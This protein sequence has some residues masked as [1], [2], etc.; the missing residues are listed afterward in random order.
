MRNPFQLPNLKALPAVVLAVLGFAMASASAQSDELLSVD[1]EPQEA[2]SALV[3]LAKTSGKQILFAKGV[4]TQVEVEG[5]KGEYRFEDALAALL[6]DTDLEYEF[7][8]ENLILVQPAKQ[9]ADSEEDEEDEESDPLELSD[10]VV[11]GSRI[12]REDWQKPGQVIVLSRED[13]ES[14][15]A[16]TLEQALRNLPQ[17]TNGVT[18]FGGSRNWGSGSDLHGRMLGTSNINGSSTINLRGLGDSATL[19][20]VDGKRVGD[21]GLLGGFSDISAIPISIIER[22]EIQLDGASS[23]YGSDAIGGVVN[24]ILRKDYD[25]MTMSFRRTSRTGGG[26]TEDNASVLGGM[27]WGSGG[28]RANVDGY[29]SSRQRQSDTN[30]SVFGTEPYGY[31]GN[32]RGRRG[33]QYGPREISPAFTQLAR[34]A[35]LIG[36]DEVVKKVA[37]PDGQDG[38]GLKLED[39]LPNIGV[40]QTTAGQD[41]PEISLT[42]KSDRL[43]FKV[44]ARQEITPSLE[45][46]G[47][48]TYGTRETFS[49]TGNPVGTRTFEV[50]AENPYNPFGRD[51]EVDALIT[52]FGT[53]SVSGE[54]DRLTLDLD[55][56]GRIG[57]R[58]E[59]EWHSRV[60]NRESM[61]TTANYV[62]HDILT[63]DLVDDE[64]K[65]CP[66]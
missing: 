63:E 33:S 3:T 57:D 31:P 13:L 11:T 14:T 56:D 55:F 27:T 52:G 4:S 18:E 40:F 20:L 62:D 65:P 64:H 43:V 38:T 15:G 30:F 10:R 25:I 53:R 35:D 41:L 45:V 8:S 1:I 24:V 16:P 37:I 49:Q 61:G 7:A 29:R 44:S 47:G 23:I 5:L 46:S 39:F 42:P 21:S 48:V 60:A 34:D 9:S 2:G 54:R 59:W 12:P 66:T 26:H 51:V 28:V 32:V 22:V 17:N 50:A 58:W 36:Q 6:T 19:I